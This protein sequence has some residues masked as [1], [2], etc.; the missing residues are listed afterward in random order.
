MCQKSFWG[1][2]LC[3]YILTQL[4]VV[5]LGNPL[6]LTI[7]WT[8]MTR[9][10]I[11]PNMQVMSEKMDDFRNRWKNYKFNSRKFDRKES[12]MQW[13]LYIHF[14]SPVHRGFLNDVSVTLIDNFSCRDWLYDFFL[15][16]MCLR[17]SGCFTWNI[18]KCKSHFTVFGGTFLYF[19][20]IFKFFRFFLQ[21]LNIFKI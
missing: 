1:L 18:V 4:L 13:H 21:T 7:G 15:V 9:Y 5:W 10:Y 17:L 6:R 14:N 8:V 12:C 11:S 2:W 16:L 19:V 3:K 20:I